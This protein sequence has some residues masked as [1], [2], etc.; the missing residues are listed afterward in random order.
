[1]GPA[2]VPGHCA[3]PYTR[4]GNSRSPAARAHGVRGRQPTTDGHRACVGGAETCAYQ[5]CSRVWRLHGARREW[6]RGGSSDMARHTQ[7]WCASWWWHTC[8]AHA[9]T[10]TCVCAHTR[11]HTQTCSVAPS[12]CAAGR[13]VPDWLSA[14]TVSRH[15]PIRRGPCV[16][17]QCELHEYVEAPP[18]HNA[19]SPCAPQCGADCVGMMIPQATCWAFALL[20]PPYHVEVRAHHPCWPL[21]VPMCSSLASTPR[22]PPQVAETHALPPCPLTLPGRHPA[23]CNHGADATAHRCYASGPLPSSHT[24]QTRVSARAHD[25]NHCHQHPYKP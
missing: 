11:T 21:A 25:C 6:A 1:M 10:H 14:L 23:D 20:V 5:S 17:R 16:R 22:Q 12:P 2:A 8:A 3:A 18:T 24:Q 15:Y 13:G 4:R 9:A 7:R 19:A